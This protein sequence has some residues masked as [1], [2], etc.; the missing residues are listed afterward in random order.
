MSINRDMREY[1]LEEEVSTRT[2]SGASKK[3]WES[4]GTIQVCVKKKNDF[5]TSSSVVFTESTHSGLTY[6]KQIKSGHM[7]LVRGQETYLI[8]DCNTDSRLT[9]LTLKAVW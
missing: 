5:R 9:N 1:T 2:P 6:H 4:R 8:T 7:R 3:S